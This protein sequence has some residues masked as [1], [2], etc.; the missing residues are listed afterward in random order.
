[1]SVFV[2]VS[3][4]LGLFWFTASLSELFVWFGSFTWGPL[5]L[6]WL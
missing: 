1:M 4:W 2:G 5:W 3:C 6:E